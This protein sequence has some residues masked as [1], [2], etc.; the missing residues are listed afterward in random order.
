MVQRPQHGDVGQHDDSASLG[1]GDQGIPWQLPM[2]ALGFGRRQ[3]QDVDTGIAQASKFAAISPVA[4][5]SSNW[6]DQPF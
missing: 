2:L 5:G 1:G 6:R 4:I 3:R